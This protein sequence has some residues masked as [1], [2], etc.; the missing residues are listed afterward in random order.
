[1]KKLINPYSS[2]ENFD[3]LKKRFEYFKAYAKQK[4]RKIAFI[5]SMNIE[6][7]IFLN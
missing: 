2:P 3:I 1:M 4:Y 6:T 7:T 5:E